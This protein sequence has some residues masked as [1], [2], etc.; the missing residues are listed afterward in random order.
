M[1]D[2]FSIEI[3]CKIISHNILLFYIIKLQNHIPYILL[4]RLFRS[5]IDLIIVKNHSWFN[6][7]LCATRSKNIVKSFYLKLYVIT[8]QLPVF[9]FYAIFHVKINFIAVQKICTQL[10]RLCGLL[11]WQIYTIVDIICHN[12]TVKFLVHHFVMQC[13][14]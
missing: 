10:Q 2:R 6:P 9:D 12:F 14:I 4:R 3:K 13:H 11:L 7:R 1:V 8:Y 5:V